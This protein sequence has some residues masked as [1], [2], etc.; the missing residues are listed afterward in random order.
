MNLNLLVGWL[1]LAFKF[2]I[3]IKCF[4]A[5]CPRSLLI[6][7]TKIHIFLYPFS[8]LTKSKFDFVYVWANR[9]MDNFTKIISF[10]NQKN[11]HNASQCT[12]CIMLNFNN[13]F[14]W[15]R[16][17][18]CLSLGHS[19]GQGI[20]NEW[21]RTEQTDI[22]THVIHT[23]KFTPNQSV[24]FFRSLMHTVCGQYSAVQPHTLSL[25]LSASLY[26]PVGDSFWYVFV[27]R[28]SLNFTVAM[29]LIL[30]FVITH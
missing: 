9:A 16:I 20:R 21:E 5:F 28:F 27:C 8:M 29:N 2:G 11:N 3:G 10:S 1:V 19:N 12:Q 4:L 26:C 14:A 17:S 30:L 24:F 7:C 6:K 25:S 23:L 15:I 18:C 13:G 22:S